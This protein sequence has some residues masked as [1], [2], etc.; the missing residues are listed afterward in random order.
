MAKLCSYYTLSPLIDQQ[1]LLGVEKDSS[2]GCAVITLGRNI[3]IRYKVSF[4][5]FRFLKEILFR[6]LETI[7]D[8]VNHTI[9]F[10][11]VFTYCCLP[12]IN[13]LLRLSK[14]I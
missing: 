4:F 10:I 8:Y 13:R 2:P 11:K 5:I 3:V 7:F 6:L 12:Y 14:Y 9:V 1:N